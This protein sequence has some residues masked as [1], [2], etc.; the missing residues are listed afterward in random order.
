MTESNTFKPCALVPVYCH[1]DVLH[2]TLATLEQ[3]S[4]DII[5]VDDGNERDLAEKL[6]Q[7]ESMR[8]QV[9]RHN[10]NKGKGAAIKTGLARAAECGYTHALQVDADGQHDLSDVPKFLE[11]SAN[12]PSAMIS[13]YP[14]YD[15]SVPK[16]RLY[17]RY[18]THVW[19][20]INTLSTEIRDSMCG[21]RVYPVQ[22]SN[23]LIKDQHLGD[24]M[25]FDID[26]IVAWYW[27]RW[28]FEQLQT[29]VVY[30]EQGWSN[31]KLL[32]DNS[33][34]SA[35]HAKHFLLLPFR[36]IGRLLR[37]LKVT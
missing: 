14:Q 8:V 9:L 1:F 2:N 35:M 7:L 10:I 13:A 32:R 18:I 20:W 29:S 22:L 33:R 25:E 30:P 4:L 15:N 28:P 19:V 12:K 11:A 31:F 34:I 24:R 3:H 21:F 27:Q 6:A 23:E 26:V 37:Y 16:G 36:I 5:L 17:A